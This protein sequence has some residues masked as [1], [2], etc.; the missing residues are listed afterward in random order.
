MPSKDQSD[1]PGKDTQWQTHTT[2]RMWVDEQ[3]GPSRP[4]SSRQG[5]C[6]YC[7]V[8]YSNLD[9]HLS[10]SAHRESVRASS[11]GSS[12][13]SSVSSSRTSSLLER[14]LHDVIQHH[15]H[16][17]NDTRPSHAD[18]PSLSCPLVPRE[19]LAELC[20]SNVDSQSLGTREDLPSSDDAS[21]QLI[22]QQEP[23]VVVTDAH[24]QSRQRICREVGQEMFST[25]IPEQDTRLSPVKHACT[26]SPPVHAHTH[27]AKTHTHPTA[28]HTHSPNI[29]A[30]TPVT[31]TPVTDTLARPP[32][33]HRKAHRKTDRRRERDSS[34]STQ[35]GGLAWT[36]WERE[37]REA[38]REE[39]FSSD[40]TD[41]MD[42]TI[43]EVIQTCCYGHTSTPHLQ[44]E[45]ESFCYSLPDSLSTGGT[46]WDTPVQVRVVVALQQCG[47][48]TNTHPSHTP[49]PVTHR[50]HTPGQVSQAE[51]RGLTCLTE[52]TVEL[53]DQVYSLQ[54]DTVLHTHTSG[55]GGGQEEQGYRGLPIEEILPAPSYIPESFRGKTWVQIEQEDEQKVERLVRQFRKGRFLCYFDSES[56]AR[57]S[58]N[59]K[60]QDHND[61]AKSGV[62]VLPLL[63]HDEDDPACIRR[64]RGKR[65][66]FRLASRCQ[67]V[68]VSHSTQTVPLVIP[69]VRQPA[70][71]RLP[72]P[73]HQEPSESPGVEK[74]P[75]IRTSLA[76]LRLPAS[77]SRIFTPLQPR[78]SLV[79]LLC[80]PDVPPPSHHAPPTSST[81]KRCRKRKRPLEPDLQGLKV[82]YKRVPFRFYD[83]TSN[84]ILQSPPKG[85][86]SNPRG[87]APKPHLSVVRQLF[88]SLSPEINSE[89]LGGEVGEAGGRKRRGGEEGSRRRG[90][91]RSRGGSSASGSAGTKGHR[92]LDT[93]SSSAVTPP[94]SHS[95]LTNGSRL[96]LG[97]LSTDSAQTSRQGAAGR[98]GRSQ[99]GGR[100]RRGGGRSPHTDHN[101]SPPHRGSRPGRGRGARKEKRGARDSSY[102]PQRRRGGP[103]RTAS[104]R[105]FPGSEGQEDISPPTHKTPPTHSPAPLSSSRSLR[106]RR[107]RG[108][109]CCNN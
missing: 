40:H 34:S 77:Y 17:Y 68:K 83:P 82:K 51:G 78:T 84:R 26:P 50:P 12:T 28:P 46:D 101:S 35:A 102:T 71:E 31:D 5:Y 97:T 86:P 3:A 81:P 93:G 88:R 63:D 23:D 104:S 21:C 92:S 90:S 13:V 10:S 64:R 66:S 30:D 75:E 98:R 73:D 37:R 94:F 72:L 36:S 39:A 54:L 9:Q 58:Q 55:G 80:S 70:P 69:T 56:L 7:R 38:H 24:S 79:Y 16:R 103:R 33:V 32:S 19:E 65:R 60:G 49:G 106:V 25:P 62:D 53:S 85:F 18:L 52:T 108:C 109:P 4:Q 45:P 105:K 44:G 42:Q 1:A 48:Y 14:F 107:V 95:S 2:R 76:S 20:I 91:G 22:H 99:G 67:V 41:P 74:T 29:H 43:E 100:E 8:I 59:K 96:P 47:T 61:E 6:G 11:R 87:S 57:R 89:R 27:S 15:P